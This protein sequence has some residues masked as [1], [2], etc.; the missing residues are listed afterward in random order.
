V[1]T[2]IAAAPEGESLVAQAVR[3]V[4]EH[5]RA[6]GLRV[7]DTLPSEQHFAGQLGVSR[8]VMREAFGA[9]A[10]L[11]LIDV[12][13]GRR[14]RVG[15]IDGS[16]IGASFEHAVT[17]EQVSITDIWD[18]RRTLELRTA[19]LAAIHRAPSEADRIV[20]HA[21]ALA[22]A[23]ELADI[24]AHDIAFHQAIAEAS[25]NL[26]FHQT[27]RAFETMM[28]V[29]VPVAWRTRTTPEQRET[30][31]ANH[32]EIAAAIEAGDP[33]RAAAAMDRH[34]DASVV[35]AFRLVG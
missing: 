21:R 9:L 6:N 27:V 33:A 20:A 26:V 5:I 18:V 28:R 22:D 17:T 29:A 12:G 23:S 4:R 16:V 31:R 19:E 15:G 1:S 32:L 34:F 11:R 8:A 24:T 10:A 3:R 14:A 25:H 2:G 13:N 30:V 35:R 7:G